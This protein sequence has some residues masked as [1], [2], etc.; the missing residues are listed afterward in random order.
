MTFS[1]FNGERG[2]VSRLE[3]KF[4]KDGALSDPYS[5]NS[6][7]VDILN[8]TG[9]AYISGLYFGSPTTIHLSG[10]SPVRSGIGIYYYDFLTL[11]GMAIGSYLDRWNGIQYTAGADVTSGVF[12][13]TIRYNTEDLSDWDVIPG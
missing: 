2:G 6:M 13:F 12:S 5:Q 9:T 4:Y 7:S 8:S 1:R 10:L 11:S 3:A